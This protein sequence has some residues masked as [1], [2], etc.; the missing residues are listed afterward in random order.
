MLHVSAP[1]C[2][3]RESTKTKNHNSTIVILHWR[4]FN[5]HTRKFREISSIGSSLKFVQE[6]IL[7]YSLSSCTVCGWST[8]WGRGNSCRNKHN[9]RTRPVLN[10]PFY[11]VLTSHKYKS[12]HV[13]T[14]FQYTEKCYS[15]DH[16]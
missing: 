2:H 8:I 6:F 14:H 16:V 4:E 9:N 15:V 1:E 3:F 5:I 7:I 10:L 13:W 12:K 11:V